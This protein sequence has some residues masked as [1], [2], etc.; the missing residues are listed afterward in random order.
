V[1]ARPG[2]TSDVAGQGR[3]TPNGTPRRRTRRARSVVGWRHGGASRPGVWSPPLSPPGGKKPVAGSRVLR[4]FRGQACE[5]QEAMEKGGAPK[6]SRPRRRAAGILI[7]WLPVRGTDL[8]H[9]RVRRPRRLTLPNLLRG[10][11]EIVPPGSVDLSVP[12]M[13]EVTRTLSAIEQGD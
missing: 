7:H 1:A 2:R 8:A 10:F 6:K 5:G 3:G 4:A 13:N 11:W 9:Q 12:P